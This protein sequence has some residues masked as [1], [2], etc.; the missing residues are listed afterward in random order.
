MQTLLFFIQLNTSFAA[1]IIN[2]ALK[3][4]SYQ[5]AFTVDVD[6]SFSDEEGLFEHPV[7]ST[8]DADLRLLQERD[9]RARPSLKSISL[10]VVL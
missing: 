6:A 3:Y 4:G 2:K 5:P 1:M 8:G 7:S 9:T 10:A